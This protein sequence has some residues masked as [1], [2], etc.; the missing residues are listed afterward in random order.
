MLSPFAALRVNSAKDLVRWGSKM[1]RFAQHDRA[2]LDV[3]EELSRSFEPCLKDIIGGVHD[4][5]APT[6]FPGMSECTTAQA[7]SP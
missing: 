4:T 1:L 7:S 3:D 5:S 2:G 6:V